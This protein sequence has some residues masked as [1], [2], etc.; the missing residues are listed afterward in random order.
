MNRRTLQSEAVLRLVAVPALALAA[1]V[2]APAAAGHST[3]IKT[4]PANDAIVDESPDQVLLHF[5]EGVET[6]LGAV[7]VYNGN[8]ERVDSE[9]I[10]QPARESVG[11]RIDDELDRGTYTVTW[12]VISADSDPIS[13]AFVFHVEEPGPQPS[14][15]AAQVLE[16][17]P[18]AVSVIYTSGR[19]V[20]F[21]L[22]LLCAGGVVT[23]VIALRSADVALRRR[24]YGV[25]AGL[26][27][28]LAIVASAGLVL[29]AAAAGGLSIGEA[30]RWSVVSSVAETRFGVFSLV[31]AGIALALLVIALILRRVNSR[32]ER[33]A[34]V[35]AV[36][37][38]VGLVVTPG[39]S[40]HASVA[41]PL[42][43]AS[44]MAHVLAAAA[45]TGGLAFLVLALVS[46]RDD[47][48]P[49][50]ARSVP[51]FSNM[52]VV[53]VALLL[54]AGIVNGYLEVRTWRGLWETTY[55]LLL[56]GKIGL[57]LPL[58]A[59]GAYNNRYA[60]PRLRRQIASVLE[61]RRFL[62]TAAAELAIMIAIVGVTAVLV[63]APPAKGELQM[64]APTTAVAELG[65]LE[66]HV[67]V[68][69]GMAGTNTIHLKF[70]GEKT[71][72]ADVN[73]SATLASK[74]IGPLRYKA[75]PMEHEGEFRVEKAELV[76]PG[77][78]Q[79]RIEARRG[80]F[81]LL[82]GNVSIPIREES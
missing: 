72:I 10:F 6:A 42:A 57:I 8:G 12:A 30:A 22:L 40:G 28:A 68:E 66:V 69:P 34:L 74:K 33:V 32:E 67:A 71:D 76:I 53:S 52:A 50:A 80:E 19:F 79:L 54:V 58:L 13:G 18:L 75:Q 55:G 21:V 26:A 63:N 29:Q 81:E 27:A 25:L 16:D 38:A 82:T 37:A 17:T 56:L 2:V 64:H 5:D 46:A 23:L 36:V 7:R 41:G 45:W 43:L 44:D 1:L 47:R 62:R 73:V 78:W 14:G 11:V 65:D 20:D 24:L 9:E 48:W 51:R 31:R 70:E 4:E 15:I 59:L 3:L 49:L 77:D 60:V 39:L 35:A 61:Q